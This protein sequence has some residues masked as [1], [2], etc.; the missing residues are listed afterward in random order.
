MNNKVTEALQ[1]FSALIEEATQKAMENDNRE[2]AYK[3][4]FLHSLVVTAI[5]A[6]MLL[7]TL[8]LAFKSALTAD[9][10]IFGDE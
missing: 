10:N 9:L 8:Q 3:Y 2:L 1:L 4:L 7:G 6:A 5:N